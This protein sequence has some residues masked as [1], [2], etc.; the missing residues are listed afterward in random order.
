MSYNFDTMSCLRSYATKYNR[1]YM[2]ALYVHDCMTEGLRY[3]SSMS[4][5]SKSH[6]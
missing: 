2:T 5:P 3:N 4:S 6:L 1:P